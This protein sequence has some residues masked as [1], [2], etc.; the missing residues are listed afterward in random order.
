MCEFCV[1]HGE[2]K[3]WYENA[4]NYTLELFESVNSEENL[5]EYLKGFYRKLRVETMRGRKL[6]KRHPRIYDWL[7]YPRSSRHLKETHFGQVVPVEDVES[8][9]RN[10]TQVVRLPCVCR[11]VTIGVAKRVCY[12][13]GLDFT[14]IYGEIPEFREFERVPVEEASEHVRS[15]DREGM[16]H[17]VWTFMTPYIGALCNCDRDCMAYRVEKTQHLAK[18][19]WKGEYVAESDPMACT[20]CRKCMKVCYFGALKYDNVNEKVLVNPGAC[21]GCG[22]CRAACDEGAMTLKDREAVPAAAGL[23]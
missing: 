7:I 3:K 23:W 22:I 19:M 8:I 12:G 16:L 1:S 4:R 6:R 2:G 9:L 15:L 17:S 18:V 21:Y 11:R 5:R 20:G 13:I 10:F 14:G